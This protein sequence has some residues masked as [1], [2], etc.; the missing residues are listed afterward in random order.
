MGHVLMQGCE[1]RYSRY[2]FSTME[3]SEFLDC[4]LEE[5]DFFECTLKDMKL[6]R[7]KMNGINFTE[8]DLKGIDLSTN[9]YDHMEVSL[10]KIAGC[11]VSKEQALGFVRVL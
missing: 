4:H 9:T 1:G 8:T 10:P 7:C 11:I 6:L 5:G 2:N 3:R